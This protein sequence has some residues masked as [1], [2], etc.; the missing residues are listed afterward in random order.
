MTAYFKAF[1]LLS[2]K[3]LAKIIYQQDDLI[4]MSLPQL[5]KTCAYL[6]MIQFV[7]DG[8]EECLDCG[9]L[10]NTCINN[11]IHA[12]IKS[13]PPIGVV[14]PTLIFTSVNKYKE[15][16]NNKIPAIVL[17]IDKVI[18]FPGYLLC[19]NPNIIKNRA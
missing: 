8:V 15:P 17:K 4:V 7:S 5:R 10:S 12:E 13:R 9:F 2:I 16:E 14:I 6:M 11:K 19:N 18:N 3:G 1:V